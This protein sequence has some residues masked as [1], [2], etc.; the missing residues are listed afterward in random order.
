MTLIALM[1]EAARTSE[2]SVDIQLRTR[3]YIPE[4]TELQMVLTSHRIASDYW[5]C[6]I[7]VELP[8]SID[9]WLLLLLS[10]LVTDFLSSLVLL[11]LSQW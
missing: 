10:S 11:L 3:Q 2:T 4:D 7:D 6:I 5:L 9:I 1:M 8:V